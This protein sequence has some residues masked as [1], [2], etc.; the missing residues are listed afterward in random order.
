M[1]EEAERRTLAREDR[2][3]ARKKAK[4]EAKAA[5]PAAPTSPVPDRPLT[6]QEEAMA[7]LA[8]AAEA[9]GLARKAMAECGRAYPEAQRF[10]AMM[11]ICEAQCQIDELVPPIA[12]PAAPDAS[13]QQMLSFLKDCRVDLQAQP[14]KLH[15]SHQ[16][17]K[18]HASLPAPSHSWGGLGRGAE[19]PRVP[20]NSK[21][22]SAELQ[23]AKLHP[24]VALTPQDLPATRRI[25]SEKLAELFAPKPVHPMIA[26]LN[27]GTIRNVPEVLPIHVKAAKATQPFASLPLPLQPEKL[28]PPHGVN[29][30][31][32]ARRRDKKRRSDGPQS[33]RSPPLA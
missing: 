19:A 11:A 25:P 21:S 27:D 4:A 16:P 22:F 10:E 8:R 12:T 17:E 6:P 7:A 2:E 23:P 26:A 18:L 32:R 30:S 20:T 29:A 5:P 24:S 9:A 1:K 3:I 13:P 33:S 14:E 31:R 28:H 15:G